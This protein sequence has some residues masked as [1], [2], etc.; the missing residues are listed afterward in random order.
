MV[1]SLLVNFEGAEQLH[2]LS[3]VEGVLSFGNKS[4]LLI[5]ADHVLVFEVF[6]FRVVEDFL[7]FGG[8][9]VFNL[10]VL[11]EAT[12]YLNSNVRLEK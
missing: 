10:H 11:F 6:E 1:W 5:I 7:Y 12:H 9:E 2:E 3:L 8:S 4:E